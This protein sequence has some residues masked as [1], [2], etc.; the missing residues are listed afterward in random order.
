VASAPRVDT[1]AAN[2]RFVAE[3]I[4][5]YYGR[6]SEVL[7]PPVDTAFFTPDPTEE[8][9]E[10][11]GDRSRSYARV[12]SALAPYKRVDLAVLAAREAGVDLVVVG[13]GPGMGA[14]RSLVDGLRRDGATGG[15]EVTLRGRVQGEE[16]RELYRRA[17]CLLQPGIEDFGIAPVEALACGTLF[18]AFKVSQPVRQQDVGNNPAGLGGSAA[19]PVELL[20]GHPHGPEWRILLHVGKRQGPVEIDHRLHSS[21][22]VGVCAAKNESAAIVLQS[23]GDNLRG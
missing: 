8:G 20:Y 3:R 23:T 18:A 1:F 12:V 14:M 19:H 7:P 5:R 11:G 10:E 4:R 17:L 15:I 21:L 22:A 9:G 6:E 2:S 13:D 16:L